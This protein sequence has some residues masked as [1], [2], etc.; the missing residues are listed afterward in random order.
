MPI[1]WPA[2]IVSREE[3][4]QWL[5]TGGTTVADDYIDFLLPLINSAIKRYCNRQFREYEV[6]GISV[7]CSSGDATAAS[8]QVTSLGITL[9]ITGGVDENT[10]TLTFATY[11]TLTDIVAAINALTGW[12]ASVEHS[13]GTVV[14]SELTPTPALGCLAQAETAT[15]GVRVDET[16]YFNGNGASGT[17]WIKRVPIQSV[18]DLYEDPDRTWD[19]TGDEIASTDYVNDPDGYWIRLTDETPFT[20]G[21]LNVR[22]RYRGGYAEADI[23]PDLKLAAF[24]YFGYQ[25]TR[26]GFEAMT[27]QPGPAE[28]A[29]I[30]F[31]MTMPAEVTA[32]L[33]QYRR[34]GF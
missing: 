1:T 8:V 14:S 11:A 20:K 10:D 13:D 29:P 24:K 26:A 16:I 12:N 27:A 17:L 28:S 4:K 33:D 7:Y 21:D 5:R 3:I 32:L 30:N 6:D 18:T 2:K 15:L 9:I 31:V 34:Y 22:L 25:K 19:D 23:P